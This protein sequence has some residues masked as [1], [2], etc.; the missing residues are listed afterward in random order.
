MVHA[1]ACRRDNARAR[2]AIAL[3]AGHF[4]RALCK[5]FADVVRRGNSPGSRA[6]KRDRMDN[7][8]AVYLRGANTGFQTRRRVNGGADGP[9]ASRADAHRRGKPAGPGRPGVLVNRRKGPRK[10][11]SAPNTLL[12]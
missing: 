2:H 1:V 11:I 7:C 8:A 10:V 9:R 12:G 6:A 3:R 4:R 5:G